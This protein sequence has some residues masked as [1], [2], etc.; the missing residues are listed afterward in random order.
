MQKPRNVRLP[1]L[2]T[3]NF[4]VPLDQF[5]EAVENA[6]DEW[7]LKIE[8]K[9]YK[10]TRK[11]E[12][13]GVM[14]YEFSTR[15]VSSSVRKDILDLFELLAFE[16]HLPREILDIEVEYNYPLDKQQGN[17]SITIDQDDLDRW[18][19]DIV[20]VDDL[21]GKYGKQ[22]KEERVRFFL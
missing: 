13:D 6:I 10:R 14:M 1:P 3:F 18:Y 9:G 17:A 16:Y 7:L 12:E 15:T 20:F 8:G 2:I 4:G 21:N 22:I 11:V 19:M 5:T